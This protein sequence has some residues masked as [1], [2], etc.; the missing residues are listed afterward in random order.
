MVKGK[1]LF[2]FKNQAMDQAVNGLPDTP[3]VDAHAQA[4]GRDFAQSLLLCFYDEG[5]VE[6]TERP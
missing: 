3:P 5:I 4:P 2:L 1:S 6:S